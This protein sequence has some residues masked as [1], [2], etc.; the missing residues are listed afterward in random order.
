MQLQAHV[1][2]ELIT[3]HIFLLDP[4]EQV[5]RKRDCFVPSQLYIIVIFMFTFVWID[6]YWHVEPLWIRL[7]DLPYSSRLTINYLNRQLE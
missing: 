1:L 2:F 4:I 7:H 6:T 5:P 3:P